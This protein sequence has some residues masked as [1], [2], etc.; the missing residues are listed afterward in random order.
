[1]CL[2]DC[3]CVCNCAGYSPGQHYEEVQAIPR[4]AKVTLLTKDAQRHHL[5]HHLDGKECKDEV[6]KVLQRVRNTGL[7]IP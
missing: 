7:G 2:C 3:F 1:M 4:V 5:D 6:V